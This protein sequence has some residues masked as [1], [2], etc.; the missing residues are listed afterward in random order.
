MDDRSPGQGWIHDLREGSFH[1]DRAMESASAAPRRLALSMAELARD[2]Y[3]AGSSE[4][5]V[6]RVLAACV[7]LVDGCAAAGASLR[8]SRDRIETPATT[9]ESASSTTG[10]QP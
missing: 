7:D 1:E 2:L 10:R 8:H 9:G 6:D 3:R 5:V 4:Q